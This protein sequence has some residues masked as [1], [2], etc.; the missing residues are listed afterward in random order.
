[1]DILFALYE[2]HGVHVANPNKCAHV[3]VTCGTKTYLK[4]IEESWEHD[5]M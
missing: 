3:L 4:T 5:N 2:K 1:M